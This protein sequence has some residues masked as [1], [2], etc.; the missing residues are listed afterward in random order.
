[1]ERDQMK[2]AVLCRY[3]PVRT[4]LYQYVPVCT[5]IYHLE[6]PVLTCTVLYSPVRIVQ[7]EIGYQLVPSCTVLYLYWKFGSGLYRLVPSCTGKSCTDLYSLVQSCTNS[8]N[9]VLTC[10]VL[11]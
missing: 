7:V 1:M 5:S 8:E 4:G 10:T 3:V 11:Y 2:C 6:N 9:P